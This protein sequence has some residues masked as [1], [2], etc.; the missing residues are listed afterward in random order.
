[1]YH[2]W[3]SQIL[4]KQLTRTSKGKAHIG[5]HQPLL[6]NLQKCSLKRRSCGLFEPYLFRFAQESSCDL[7]L[8]EIFSICWVGHFFSNHNDLFSRK[9]MTGNL[10]KLSFRA[11]RTLGYR[12]LSCISK[13]QH[14]I[15]KNSKIYLLKLLDNFKNIRLICEFI[16]VN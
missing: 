15:M 12:M 9:M 13:I 6:S 1:M 5:K 7:F 8:R 16:R 11:K 2:H 3:P 10:I 14:Q 4:F